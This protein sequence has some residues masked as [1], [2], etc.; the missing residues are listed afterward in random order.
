M[1]L[2]VLILSI[3]LTTSYA[4]PVVDLQ[5]NELKR[6]SQYYVLPAIRGPTGGGLKLAPLHCTCPLY[7]ARE[8]SEVDRGLPVMFFPE[9]PDRP[10]IQEGGTLYAM[11]AV[12]TECSDST[13]W[14]RENDTIS[15]GGTVS[16]SV[17]THFSRFSI[18]RADEFAESAYKILSCPC[19]ID[20][21]RGSCLRGCSEVDSVPH[22]VVFVSANVE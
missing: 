6:G 21:D 22:T 10:I 17:G 18:V 15:T 16:S 13:V 11:F 7:V 1:E 20:V 8:E 5:G 14:Q 4:V 9:N 2:A 3:L 19:S 12:P